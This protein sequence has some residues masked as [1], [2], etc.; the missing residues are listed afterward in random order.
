M[1]T[2][3]HIVIV[4]DDTLLR[5]SLVN[6]YQKH[7]FNTS[8]FDCA[9]P[10]YDF[11]KQ[12][13]QHEFGE[14]VLI[15]SDIILPGESG[16]ALFDK[17]ADFPALGKILISINSNEQDRI[18]GLH[19]GADDYICKP[20]NSEELLLRTNALLKR[21]NSKYSA[22]FTKISF[23]GYALDPESRELSTVNQHT[24][25]SYYEN[26]LLLTLIGGQGKV[27]DRLMIANA[28]YNNKE[29]SNDFLSGRAMDVLVGRLRKKFIQLDEK[30]DLI[31]TLRGKGYM[32][33]A[34]IDR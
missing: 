21:L 33:R 30:A 27:C 11:I 4:E 2:V 28:L 34:D 19:S 12:G 29:D 20:V 15:I 23:L 1:N 16:L 9:E 3:Q 13:E 31:L 18:Q 22:Y 26:R 5:K 6:F 7:G 24:I 25:L 17:L 14:V 8:A 10:V 32:L